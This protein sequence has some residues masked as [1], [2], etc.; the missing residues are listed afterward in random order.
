MRP[1]SVATAKKYASDI[2]DAIFVSAYNINRFP[3]AFAGGGHINVG[4]LQLTAHPLLLR[5]FLMDF[6][7]HN[8]LSLG[9]FSYDTNNAMAFDL[10]R[11]GIKNQILKEFSDFDSTS[12]SKTEI[13]FL[14][15]QL[16]KIQSGDTD[17][18]SKHWYAD[19]S[20]EERLHADTDFPR[21][22]PRG[23]KG[24]ALSLFYARAILKERDRRLE[25]RA[26]RPQKDFFTYID[27]IE[28]IQARIQF[29]AKFDRA[30]PYQPLVDIFD[31]ALTEPQNYLL[32]PP[33]D[34]Q[35]ALQAFYTYVTESGQDWSRHRNYVWPDWSNGDE[36]NKFE[37]SDWF[38][39]RERNKK[40]QVRKRSCEGLLSP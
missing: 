18:Y 2:Q 23:S 33:V 34:P 39:S 38:Q 7:N 16:E 27:Q 8:E 25:F 21:Y 37:S 28:L 36:L 35:S 14:F 12:P 22:L 17:E 9:I 13:E 3:Q 26:V 5:N 32:S 6:Y 15:N 40:S 29:L 20:E 11:P 19:E 24:H 1:M 30:I 4:T 10:Q 31:D